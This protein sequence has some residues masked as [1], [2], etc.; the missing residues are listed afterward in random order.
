LSIRSSCLERA[1]AT[2]LTLLARWHPSAASRFTLRLTETLLYL[3][4]LG[5]WA[6][7]TQLAGLNAARTTSWSELVYSGSTELTVAMAYCPLSKRTV[8]GEGPLVLARPGVG[9]TTING[10]GLGQL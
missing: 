4:S 1:M 6:I 9:G 2:G 10:C 3:I 8:R 7:E 5:S